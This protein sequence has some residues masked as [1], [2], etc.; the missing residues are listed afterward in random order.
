ME[1]RQL[2]YLVAVAEEGTFTR[3]AARLHV[4]Q[5]GVS[6]QIQALERELGA[7]LLDRSGRTVTPTE[8]GAAVLPY[9][10]SA[11]AAV[12]GV[13]ETVEELTG[14]LRGRVAIGTVS[15]VS[16]ARLDLPNLLAAFHRAHPAVEITLAVAG[17]DQLIEAVHTG[18]FDLALIGLGTAEPL[19]LVLHI[20]RAEPLVAVVGH[21]D[22]L[23][24]RSSISLHELT[25][26][27]VISLR[28]G[29][30][31][32]GCLDE[33]ASA[34]GITPRISF[35]AGDP[36]MLAE[37]AA[38]GL[39]VAIVPRSLAE[40][41]RHALHAVANTDPEMTGRIALAWRAEGSMSPAATALIDQIRATRD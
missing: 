27:A 17:S 24:R 12:G 16:T 9:A 19:G 4:A 25:D 13:R 1:L 11:L 36:Y 8:A 22:P 14:L 26:R 30:G 21:D 15:A 28:R 34:A 23:T 6:A 33:A 18:R 35:E 41:R 38:C 7:T 32:R 20:L 40:T 2:T 39:G 3:A 31:L 5:P 29:T 37:L 10:R